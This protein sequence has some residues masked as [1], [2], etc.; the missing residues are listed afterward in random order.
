MRADGTL[1][2]LAKLKPFFDKRFGNVTA[3]NSSQVTDGAALLL[4]AS[5]EAVREHQLPV[6]GRVVDVSWAGLDPAV[7][8]LGPVFASTPL[9]QRHQLSLSDIDAWE[10]NE[11]FAAQLIGCL[12][13]WES[14]DFCRQALGLE[15][16]MGSID[17][18]R[19]NVDGGAI[20]VGHPLAG[21]GA[22]LVLHLLQVLKRQKGRYGVATLCI[23]G[24]QGGAMLLESTDTVE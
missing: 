6:L 13:A 20:A 3:G 11:S 24:G 5:A 9:L 19:L 22:R 7:M 18:A 12:K 4:L 23:G 1:E 21:S 10:I 2:K 16:A 17:R 8:G 14:P 15:K